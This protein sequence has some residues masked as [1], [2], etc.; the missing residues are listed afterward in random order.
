MR[1]QLYAR[2]DHLLLFAFISSR[3]VDGEAVCRPGDF[4]I[5]RCLAKRLA[6]LESGVSVPVVQCKL[7]GPSCNHLIA[8]RMCEAVASK[9]KLQV[10]RGFGSG[11]HFPSQASA[12]SDNAS[13]RKV[14]A[15][16]WNCSLLPCN[17]RETHKGTQDYWKTLN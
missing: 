16:G 15:V 5:S 17:S 14:W 8:I 10:F 9:L 4:S 2:S 1:L 11:S 12:M 6:P 3:G 13:S 7:T